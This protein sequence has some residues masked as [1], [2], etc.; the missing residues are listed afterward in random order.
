M[1]A[2]NKRSSNGRGIEIIE[3]EVEVDEDIQLRAY[4]DSENETLQLRTQPNGIK[5]VDYVDDDE[6]IECVEIVEVGEN[7][8]KSFKPKNYKRME[9]SPLYQ[10]EVLLMNSLNL[11]I[12]EV[13]T[14]FDEVVMFMP[15]QIISENL[16]QHEDCV[17]G[18]EIVVLDDNPF[19]IQQSQE[20]IGWR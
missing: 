5:D 3:L 13:T 9:T 7:Y 18:D 6:D 20:E 12:R 17:D 10:P 4:D 15:R 19:K 1:G 8:I 11:K 14:S 2:L 16:G